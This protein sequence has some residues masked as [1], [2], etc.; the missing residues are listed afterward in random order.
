VFPGGGETLLILF[1]VVL[2][3]FGP[4]QLPKLAKAVGSAMREF[5]KA[6]HEVTEELTREPTES[7]PTAERK[8]TETKPP[9]S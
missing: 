5:R 9:V 3:I 8:D 7:K 4:S 1:L 6:Q 2:L